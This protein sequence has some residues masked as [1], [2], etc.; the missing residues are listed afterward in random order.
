MFR[1]SLYLTGCTRFAISE[2]HLCPN[3]G[4]FAVQVVIGF[5][6]KIFRKNSNLRVHAPARDVWGSDR[7]ALDGAGNRPESAK[8]GWFRRVF[9]GFWARFPR[10][11]PPSRAAA[12]RPHPAP[13]LP[14]SVLTNKPGGAT[15]N[16]RVVGAVMRAAPSR[17]VRFHGADETPRARLPAP[18][19]EPSGCGRIRD[20]RS[21]GPAGRRIFAGCSVTRGGSGGSTAVPDGAAT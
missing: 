2:M 18:D 21:R 13:G 17:P 7:G 3:A 4:R 15:R 20:C 10:L 12:P 6:I 16:P 8:M 14:G 9:G 5:T 19:G 1:I 11:D